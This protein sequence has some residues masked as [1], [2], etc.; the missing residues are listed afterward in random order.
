[1]N[2]GHTFHYFLEMEI[3]LEKYES[4]SNFVM[5]TN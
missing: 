1:M 3:K 5:E 2:Q 4:F